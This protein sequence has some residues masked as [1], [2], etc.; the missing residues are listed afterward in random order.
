MTE[1]NNNH[2]AR[3]SKK[4]AAP[5]SDVW[6]ALTSPE[7][8][9]QYMFGTEVVTDWEPG[10]EIVWVGEWEGEKYRDKGVVLAFEPEQRIS[11]SH[12]STASGDEDISGNHHIVNIELSNI[13]G[14]T[15]IDLTQDNNPSEEARNHAETNWDQ[16]L[17]GLQQLVEDGS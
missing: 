5:A 8:I 3:V 13:E 17:T 4:V 15:V 6:D 1:K 12:F 2:I 11:Y 9:G 10:S 16:M 7:K 14:D